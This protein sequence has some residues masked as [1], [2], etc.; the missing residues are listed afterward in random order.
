MQLPQDIH[1]YSNDQMIG[2]IRQLCNNHESEIANYKNKISELNSKVDNLI[3]TISILN[4]GIFGRKSERYVEENN[5]QQLSLDLPIEIEEAQKTPQVIIAPAEVEVQSHESKKKALKPSRRLLPAE[6]PREDI[7][8]EPEN[9]TADMVRIGEEQTEV[10]HVRRREFFVKR[11]IRPKYAVKGNSDSGVI[12]ADVPSLPF[13]KCMASSTLI[14]MILIDKYLDHLPLHRQQ[15][16]FLRSNIDIKLST[17]N[18]WVRKAF[19]LLN[20]LYEAHERLMTQSNYLMSD[21][22][23]LR[24]LDR[25]LKGKSH[26]GYLWGYYD[27]VNKNVLFRYCRGRGKLH[28]DSFFKKLNKCTVQTDGYV[29]YDNMTKRFPHLKHAG[30]MAHARRFFIDA[31]NVEKVKCDWMLKRVKGL[32]DI[33]A[34]ARENNYTFEER[35]ALR[36]SQSTPILNEMHAWLKEE[37]NTAGKKN[38]FKKAVNY[39]LGRWQELTQF[40]KDGMLE[41][42]NNLI[43]NKIRPIALGRKN[44]M[45]AGNHDAAQDNAMI[46]SL[47]ATCMQHDVNPEEWLIFVLDRIADWPINRIEELLPQNFKTLQ[48]AA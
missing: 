48:A 23:T 24:V 47:L 3:H 31:Q 18:E 1:N 15:K 41:I 9:I 34:F 7:V 5:S 35:L 39:M 40:C 21:E 33:E 38:A 37:L 29:V 45:F 26:Q 8:L 25:T 17:M 12:I 22:T 13:P 30:C 6:L 16:R 4:K 42:D 10:L 36:K 14:A 11:Y 43:E 19:N 28:A 46:Y 2:L 20:P 44:F 32:Y 27:P